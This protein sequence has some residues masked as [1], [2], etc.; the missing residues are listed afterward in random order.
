MQHVDKE[1]ATFKITTNVVTVAIFESVFRMHRT[2][3]S[4]IPPVKRNETWLIVL[5]I[6]HKP[7]ALG[8]IHWNGSLKNVFIIQSVPEEELS[9]E[10]FKI[11]SNFFCFMTRTMRMILVQTVLMMEIYWD[12]HCNKA[13]VGHSKTIMVMKMT[14]RT[15]TVMLTMIMTTITRM[16]RTIL[17]LHDVCHQ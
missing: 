3:K 15:T 13:I 11:E 9:F 5:L 6:K 1:V 14:I 2:N 17:F 8:W 7:Q 4:K 16:P 10:W 12:D